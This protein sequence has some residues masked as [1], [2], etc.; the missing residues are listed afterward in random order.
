MR[1]GVAA[2]ALVLGVLGVAA[3]GP[4]P[5][6][7]AGGPDDVEVTGEFGL[8]PTVTFETPLVVDTESV[9]TVIDGDGDELVE[10]AP[11]LVDWIG[12]DGSTGALLGETYATAPEVFAFS[13]ESLGDDLYAAVA[14]SGTGDRVLYL[15]PTE[16]ATGVRGAHVVVVDVRP[17]RAQG[18]QMAPGE[19]LPTVSLAED[20]APT[21][22]VP[23]GDPP[24]TLIQHPLVRGAGEQ[25]GAESLLIVQ[26]TGVRWSDGGVEATTWGDGRLPQQLDMAT[27][28]P[29]LA[30][31]LLDQTVGSQVL[32]V[33]PPDLAFGSDTLVFV[34]DVLA[35]VRE[36]EPAA[37][38]AE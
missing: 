28:I 34:V 27:T 21:I 33:V 9:T 1:R 25:V 4:E 26:Y 20:G 32:V 30:Q 5:R 18:E 10:G 12:F 8:R 29:G 35:L 38:P 11:V 6:V 36:S 37:T 22:S 14:A 13:Q 31:G 19:G 7:P 3:C 16:V 17:A 24:A 23:D 2:A 15:Q